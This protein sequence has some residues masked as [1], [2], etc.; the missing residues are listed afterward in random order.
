MRNSPEKNLCL[1]KLS[2]NRQAAFEIMKEGY[3]FVLGI[4]PESGVLP[5]EKV[6]ILRRE[7]LEIGRR[8][9]ALLTPEQDVEGE[10]VAREEKN[11]N[12]KSLEVSGS[13]KTN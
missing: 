2:R 8:V 4:L 11:P 10:I 6:H 5:E 12:L 3:G 13:F 9:E 1:L 7:V